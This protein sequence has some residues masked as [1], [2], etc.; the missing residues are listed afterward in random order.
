MEKPVAKNYFQ[1]GIRENNNVKDKEEDDA[2]VID[3]LKTKKKDPIPNSN[4]FSMGPLL[5]D[6]V[7]DHDPSTQHTYDTAYTHGTFKNSSKA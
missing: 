4:R 5:L 1:E 7:N 6:S 3:V 2:V